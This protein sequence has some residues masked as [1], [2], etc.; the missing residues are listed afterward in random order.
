MQSGKILPVIRQ[1]FGTAIEPKAGKKDSQSG[2]QNSQENN[3]EPTEEEIFQALEILNAQEE[4]QSSGLSAVAEKV[5]GKVAL[6]MRDS[7]GTVLRVLRAADVH[8]IL[9]TGKVGGKGNQI[10]RILDRRI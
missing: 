8:R 6:M 1:F 9:S 2:Y 5:Q 10:G 4:I 7:H 3:R